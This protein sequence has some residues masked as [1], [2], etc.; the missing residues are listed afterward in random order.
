[1]TQEQ[2]DD[3]F[4]KIILKNK[5]KELKQK[6]LQSESATSPSLS[7]SFIEGELFVTDII[8]DQRLKLLAPGD[9]V[10]WSDVPPSIA[11]F[12]PFTVIKIVGEYVYVGWV[13]R[14]I[15][16][17]KL[18]IVS[19]CDQT[20]VKSDRNLYPVSDANQKEKT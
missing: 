12:N 8:S 20:Y 14:E 7:L 15:H 18:S 9:V 13:Y 5:N 17:S 10:L 4:T 11:M 6:N 16:Y 19:C 3:I 1:M 2:I